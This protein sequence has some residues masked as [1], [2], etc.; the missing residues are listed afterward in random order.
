MG[1]LLTLGIEGLI[2]LFP[3]KDNKKT[4]ENSSQTK[5][6]NNAIKNEERLELNKRKS[7]QINRFRLVNEVLLYL[8]M[9][10]F[11]LLISSQTAI[12]FVPRPSIPSGLYGTFL[13]VK[14]IRD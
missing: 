10:V 7:F 2:K 14:K 1:W 5:I 13:E 4:K 6:A 12:S 9:G 8:G 3:R 11:F